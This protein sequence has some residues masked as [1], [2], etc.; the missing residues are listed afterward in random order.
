MRLVEATIMRLLRFRI[1]ILIIYYISIALFIESQKTNKQY[2]MTGQ[3]IE[4]K[5]L[6]SASY[7][8]REGQFMA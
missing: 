8:D 1:I 6:K 5:S 4:A 3:P 7:E 2:I